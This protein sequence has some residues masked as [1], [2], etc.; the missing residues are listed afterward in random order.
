MISILMT[1]NTHKVEDR[2]TIV[3]LG[4]GNFKENHLLLSASNDL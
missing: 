3:Q 1:H 2:L 4:G